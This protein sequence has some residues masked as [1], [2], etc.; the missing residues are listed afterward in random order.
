[1]KK[2]QI[3]EKLFIELIKYHLYDADNQ[4]LIKRGLEEKLEAL[5]KRDLYTKSKVAQTDT[6]REEA[7]K[8]Y[9]NIAGIQRKYN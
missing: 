3:D 1:M 8:A 2:I 6:E 9:L 4:E 7:R 5:E